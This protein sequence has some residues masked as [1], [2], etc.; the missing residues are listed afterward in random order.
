[1]QIYAL[2]RNVSSIFLNKEICQR[3]NCTVTEYFKHFLTM[4]NPHS[5]Q[6]SRTW[7]IPPSHVALLFLLLYIYIYIYIYFFFGGGEL[8]HSTPVLLYKY[9]QYVYFDPSIARFY[10]LPVKGVTHFY[11]LCLFLRFYSFCF[12][13]TCFLVYILSFY[14]ICCLML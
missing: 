11:N 1:M 8:C 13:F 14:L 4:S 10:N 2:N 5:E 6:I 9:L 7:S 3:N 12:Y